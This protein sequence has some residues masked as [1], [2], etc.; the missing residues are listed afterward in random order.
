MTALDQEIFSKALAFLSVAIKEDAVAD[1][2]AADRVQKFTAM[3][4]D[5]CPSQPANDITGT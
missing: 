5:F 1:G 2:A 4:E 3:L